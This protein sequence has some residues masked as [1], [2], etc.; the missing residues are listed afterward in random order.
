M[1]RAKG[2]TVIEVMVVVSIL[3][4]VVTA[5]LGTLV[6]ASRTGR[7]M[8]AVSVIEQTGR[9]ALDEI[10]RDLRRAQEES[11][12]LTAAPPSLTVSFRPVEGYADGAAVLGEPMAFVTAPE[13][14]ESD[15]GV[16]DDGD[17]LVDEQ[18]I[19]RSEGTTA[20][21]LMRNVVE[22]SFVVDA[23]GPGLRIAFVAQTTRSSGQTVT[24]AF[25]TSVGSRN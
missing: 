17:G 23:S 19:F 7:T 2:M 24:R 5:I 1:S 21:V 14:G 18:A 15:N 20:R 11:I 9:R 25:A 3:S 22:G 8:Q 6:A 13:P 12:E 16:D 4:A 10:A